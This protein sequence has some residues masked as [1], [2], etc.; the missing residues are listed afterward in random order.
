MTSSCTDFAQ[1]TLIAAAWLAVSTTVRPLLAAL[2]TA[3]W[4]VL[5]L[6]AETTCGDAGVHRRFIG[7][8]G[9]RPHMVTRPDATPLRRRP[10]PV[11]PPEDG[12]TMLSGLVIFVRPEPP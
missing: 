12:R 8:H 4:N 3:L 10:L 1:V 6:L 9:R 5:S 7:P 11:N 2:V